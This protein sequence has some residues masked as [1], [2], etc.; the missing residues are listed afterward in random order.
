MVLSMNHFLSIND[1]PIDQPKPTSPLVD[2]SDRK[3][4]VKATEKGNE[5]ALKDFDAA[6]LAQSKPAPPTSNDAPKPHVKPERAED[7]SDQKFYNM[8]ADRENTIIDLENKAASLQRDID[9]LGTSSSSVTQT[10]RAEFADTQAQIALLNGTETYGAA[11]AGS[12]GLPRRKTQDQ[13]IQDNAP[14]LILPEGQYNLPADPQDFIDNSRLVEERSA[15][16]DLSWRDNPL[17]NPFYARDRELGDNTNGSTDDDF[18]AADVADSDHPVYLDL[19]NSQRGQL[20]DRNAPILY[21]TEQNEN[22]DTTRI[23]Y[24]FHYAYNEGP[25]RDGPGPLDIASGQNHEGD[26]ERITVEIDPE[27]QQ[28]THVVFSA[29]EAP[30]ERLAIN[31]EDPNERQVEI[32]DGHPVVYVADG[33]HGSYAEPGTDHHTSDPTGFFQDRTAIDTNGDGRVDQRDEG[34]VVID[35][36]DQLQNVE[37][38]AWYPEDGAG[39]RWGQIGDTPWTNG[40]EGPSEQKSHV[41]ENG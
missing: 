16:G 20:G 7:P 3:F 17:T 10:M 14:I 31:P 13:L 29:H 35:T 40:P 4:Y 18:T 38:Q 27:T 36:S 33:S 37:D 12:L 9:A 25:R 41:T 26:F 1:V 5:Q 32:R 30:H 21:E 6:L 19:D 23:T 22:G 34:V 39:V 8:A 15:T 24:W 2:A 11:D 28:A